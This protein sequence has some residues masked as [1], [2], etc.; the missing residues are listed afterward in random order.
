MSKCYFCKEHIVY[1]GGDSFAHCRHCEKKYGLHSVYS[2]IDNHY[3]HIYAM[4]NHNIIHV[5]LRPQL[6]F[7]E[8]MYYES[9]I[10]LSGFPLSPENVKEKLPLYL[11]FS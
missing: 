1:A 4:I 9:P 8:I 10:I 3:A 2:I 5:R 6:N 7:T 11:T